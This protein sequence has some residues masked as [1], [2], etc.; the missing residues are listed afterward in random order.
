MVA[1]RPRVV[2]LLL[3]R[4]RH[5][6][7]PT[8]GGAQPPRR[9]RPL[10]REAAVAGRALAQRQPP[11]AA[12]RQL[13]AHR[14]PPGPRPLLHPTDR[15]QP[16]GVRPRAEDRPGDKDA[17]GH[18]EA[19]GRVPAPDADAGG[20]Q[21]PPHLQRAHVRLHG[22]AAAP[23]EG[24]PAGVR[25]EAVHGPRVAVGRAHAAHLEGHRPLQEQGRLPPLRRL[26]PGA[27]RHRDLRHHAALPRRPLAHRPH[28]P[29][30]ARL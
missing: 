5:G 19:A 29:R 25:G 17:R 27:H 11:A 13:R 7:V 16:Q 2:L 30:R 9:G 20:R 26:L 23:Q 15:S 28:L 14:D 1:G 3:C 10:R 12:A 8:A 21:E 4:S 6:L 24:A 22:R 18:D